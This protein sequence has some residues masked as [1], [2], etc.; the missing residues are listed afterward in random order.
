M[1]LKEAAGAL[2]VHYQ[3][4][5]KW[6]RDGELTAVRIGGR[7]DVSP[8]AVAQFRANRRAVLTDVSAPRDR[9]PSD[10]TEEDALEQLEAMGTDPFVSVLPAATLAARSGA[11]ALGDLCLVVRIGDE[12]TIDFC[13]VDHPAPDHAAFVAGA[14]HVTQG[15]LVSSSGIAYAAYSEQRVVRLDHVPQDKIRTIVRPEMRQHL[16]LFPI[17][18]LLASPIAIA[19]T[20]GGVLV[21]TRDSPGAPY[22]DTDEQFAIRMSTRIG[23]LFETAREVESAWTA[24]GE[25]VATLRETLA[26][27]SVG[28]MPSPVE[29]EALL[30]SCTAADGLLIG[31]LD[32]KCRYLTVSAGFSTVTGHP[33]SAFIGKTFESFTHPD[34]RATERT[35]F[36][37]L[38]S[39]ELDFL[40][41]HARRLLVDGTDVVYASHRAAIR[42]PDATLR[43]IVTVARPLHIPKADYATVAH[44]P[45]Q[46][47]EVV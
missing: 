20:P 28:S 25:L 13:A 1:N 17:H 45:L 30:E 21:F 19:G 11:K 26:T 14:L 34:D 37:R 44:K 35:N 3:T 42:D 5:Y 32:A 29:L 36:D 31:I 12:G 38:A 24:R 39:G 40:D 43:Y 6:V 9:Q 10:L 33:T 2:D 27:R 4:A 18:S 41:I 47:T 7:Y 23:A 8:A 22:T 46:T 16:S 15:R